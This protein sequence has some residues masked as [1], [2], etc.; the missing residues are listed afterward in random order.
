MVAAALAA[1]LGPH[2]GIVF[3][4]VV[5]GGWAAYFFLH[6][7]AGRPAPIAPALT[8]TLLPALWLLATVAGPVGLG[9]RTLPQV[10][11]SPAAE[12]LLAPLLLLAAWGVT[13]LWPLQRQLPGA[14]LAPLGA[15]LLVRVAL[16]TVPLGLDY[17]RPV[18]VP[19]L[20][21]GLWH[22]AG[23]ARWALLA[24]GAAVL[25]AAG[26]TPAGPS[27]AV[28]LLPVG[29]AVELATMRSLPP[30]AWMILR[31]VTWLPSAWGGLL[32]L[33]GGLRSEVVYTAAG[34]L[35]LA[36]VV[37]PGS[38]RGGANPSDAR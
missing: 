30:R 12:I 16:P 15:V 28:W 14:L 38:A 7:Q 9:V 6:P 29:P 32:V 5:A 2:T 23:H 19:V 11:L 10:P 35:V 26:S 33:E 21:I 18:A 4:G 36:L 13:G 1:L 27:G 24:A 17:W 34:A 3:A 8:L 37:V 22:A 25:G 31:A 20:V